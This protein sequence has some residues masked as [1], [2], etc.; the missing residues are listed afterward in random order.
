MN[1][2]INQQSGSNAVAT[3]A[4]ANQTV[5]TNKLNYIPAASSSSSVGSTSFNSQKSS[6]P[7]PIGASS[8]LYFNPNSN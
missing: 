1:S 6:M 8:Y 3:P 5:K 7:M 4:N 2:T